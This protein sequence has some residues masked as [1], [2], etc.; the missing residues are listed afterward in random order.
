MARQ[1]SEQPLAVCHRETATLRLGPDRIGKLLE[2]CRLT[3][4]SRIEFALE[5]IER[6]ITA[7]ITI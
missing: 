1:R 5:C 2:Q 6:K 4:H 3:R 7:G